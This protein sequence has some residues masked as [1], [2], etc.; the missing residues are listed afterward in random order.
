MKMRKAR[1]KCFYPLVE[2]DLVT[3]SELQRKKAY[4]DYREYCL[5][6]YSY[7]HYCDKKTTREK[8]LKGKDLTQPTDN[9]NK[10]FMSMR[11]TCISPIMVVQSM[12]DIN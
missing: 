1:K 10:L 11:K 8:A 9:M 5:K 7:F 12:K 6:N 3:I 2:F 4:K